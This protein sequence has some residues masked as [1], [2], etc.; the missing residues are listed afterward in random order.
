MD[1]RKIG[2]VKNIHLSGK[3]NRSYPDRFLRKHGRM[4]I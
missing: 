1:I 4:N 3:L 2:W